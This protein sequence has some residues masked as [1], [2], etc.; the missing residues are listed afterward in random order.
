MK[1]LIA[2]ALVLVIALSLAACGGGGS[3][4]SSSRAASSTPPA[5]SS[6]PAQTPPSSTPQSTPETEP[7]AEAPA[8][9]EWP[10]N[11]YTAQVPQLPE[12]IEILQAYEI[13]SQGNFTLDFVE[14]ITYADGEAYAEELTGAGFTVEAS[15]Q[16]DNWYFTGD[17][18]AG[19]KVR[20][21]KNC[22]IIEKTQ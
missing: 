15:A 22:L 13:Q 10:D 1:K 7:E 5:S 9:V 21:L 12:T 17:N 14:Q 6:A 16:I 19:Y 3:S 8:S 11:D 20:L 2:L 18:G 4:S